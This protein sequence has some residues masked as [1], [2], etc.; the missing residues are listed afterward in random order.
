MHLIFNL[1]GFIPVL[2]DRT[3]SPEAVLCAMLHNACSYTGLPLPSPPPL[4]TD[5][6]NS[7]V[8]ETI[9]D[10]V[11][12]KLGA[13]PTPRVAKLVYLKAGIFQLELN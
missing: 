11:E 5:Q 2:K 9:C 10:I 3:M 13:T 12:N 1:T 8:F 4:S 7:D 6:L